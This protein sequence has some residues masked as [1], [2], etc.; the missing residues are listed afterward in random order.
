MYPGREFSYGTL[1][2][3]VDYA[4]WPIFGDLSSLTDFFEE[5]VCDSTN[6]LDCVRKNFI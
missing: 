4:Y 2:K 1:K 3:I 6:S 5:S